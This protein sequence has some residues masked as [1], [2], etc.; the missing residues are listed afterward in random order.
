MFIPSVSSLV[1]AVHVISCI[2]RIH[3]SMYVYR[4]VRTLIILD[5]FAH[6]WNVLFTLPSIALLLYFSFTCCPY[7]LTF[8]I[9]HTL[10]GRIDEIDDFFSVGHKNYL[11]LYAVDVIFFQTFFSFFFVIFFF[12]ECLLHLSLGI[13][14][15]IINFVCFVFS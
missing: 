10:R 5:S 7:Y 14:L 4:L 12:I 8:L 9:L 13:Q 15:N 6:A 11:V 3:I 1:G 2:P